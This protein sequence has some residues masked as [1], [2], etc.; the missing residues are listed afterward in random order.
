MLV[1]LVREVIQAVNQHVLFNAEQETM[2]HCIGDQ[3]FTTDAQQTPARDCHRCK[4]PRNVDPW[5]PKAQCKPYSH[6]LIHLLLPKNCYSAAEPAAP[7]RTRT[8]PRYGTIKTKPAEKT[9]I[10]M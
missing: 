4:I 2:S 1:Q 7:K 9:Y 6:V 5:P 8:D 10:A 3:T